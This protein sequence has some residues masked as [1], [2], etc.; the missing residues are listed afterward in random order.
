MN[1]IRALKVLKPVYKSGSSAGGEMA[2]G[3]VSLRDAEL[4][5]N[6]DQLI[7]YLCGCL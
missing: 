6:L 3:L 1:E 4:A 2:F 7:L 5:A